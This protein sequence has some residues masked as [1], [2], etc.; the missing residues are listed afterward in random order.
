MTIIKPLLAKDVDEDRLQFPC[1]VMPKIDGSFAMNWE[2]QLLARS[3]KQHENKYTTQ[4]YSIPD[5]HGLR[6]EL[7]IGDDPTAEGLC[8]N[9]SSAIRRIEGTPETS[10]WCFD[11]VTAETA[12]LAYA[13]RI[14]LLDAKVAELNNKGYDFITYIGSVTVNSLQ[15]YVGVRNRFMNLGYEGIVVRNPS[16]KHKEGRSSSTKA[17]LWRWKPYA[18]A[19]IRCTA[20]VEQMHNANEATTN[21]LGRTERSS[22]KQNL[23]GKQTLGAIVG[24]LVH[25][26][27]DFNGNVVAVAGTELTIA[28]GSL[29]DKQC[30]HLWDNPSEIIK[31]LV[32]FEYCNFGLK[33][34]PRFSQ[35]KR[36]RSERDM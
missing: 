25:D 32:E 28:T 20:L 33:D 23:V 8:R 35:F 5:F 4:Q 10:L 2:G 29:T 12:D 21:E 3:L 6:G 31:Q 26:L 11:Y 9:T 27:T 17:D 18:T 14:K 13:E 36:I 24:E 16:S 22:H 30:K 15:E 7:I 34:K 19:E 1:I